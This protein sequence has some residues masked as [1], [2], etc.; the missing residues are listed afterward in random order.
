MIDA[1]G[2]R[3]QHHSHSLGLMQVSLEMTLSAIGLR[4][5]ARAL[6]IVAPCLPGARFPSANT[7]QLWLFRFGLAQLNR[8][9]EIADDWIWLIDHTIQTGNGKCLVVLGIRSSDW[10][11]KREAF[12]A[13]NPTGK[14]SLCYEDLVP[15]LIKR[16]NTST[17]PDVCA[18]LEMLSADTG[19]IPA[20]I[21]SDQGADVRNGG[22][23][24]GASPERRT[25]VVH[26]IAHAVAN[27]LKRQL[28]KNV[29]WNSFTS[30]ANRFKTKI[31]QCSL[32]F[33][34]PPDLKQKAR[35]MNLQT[36]I[37]WSERM[38]QF[39]R[40]PEKVFE[41]VVVGEE[42]T[43]DPDAK[44]KRTAKIGQLTEA[45]REKLSW[46]EKYRY[47][48]SQWRITLLAVAI[49]LNHIRNF[50]YHR[51]AVS[52]LRVELAD[53][54]CEM[55]GKVI[56]EVLLFVQEQSRHTESGPI[57]GSTEILESLIGRGKQLQGK[58]KNGYTASVLGMAASMGKLTIETIEASL[59]EVKVAD[60]IQWARKYIG[61]SIH[62][63]RMR[64][65]AALAGTKTG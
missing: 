57:L 52:E 62:A 2:Q 64:A 41:A 6:K 26:D 25:V 58:N 30:D 13:E 44:A 37:D 51:E 28:S 7:I 56:K 60:T 65:S 42:A 16:V 35:W 46:I 9:K 54:Q 20:F 48:L 45:A 61:I 43:D 39:L 15:F 10:N 29:A 38:E 12:L 63:Q 21:L 55:A 17:G 32:A 53:I 24:F 59:K 36:L 27:A 8:P 40:I 49:I 5:A 14:F 31:R 22:Q 50:G 47:A 34:M 4:P 11:R 19:I 1:F 3:V 18:E 23:L 33:L